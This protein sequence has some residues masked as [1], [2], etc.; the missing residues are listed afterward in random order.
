MQ[1]ESKITR[2]SIITKLV[3]TLKPLNY[4]HAMWEGGAAAF[5]RIDQYS[6][7]DLYILAKKRKTNLIIKHVENAL[8]SLSGINKQLSV[9]HSQWSDLTQIFYQLQRTSKYLLI[10]LV[11]L[12]QES[13]EKFLDPRVHGKVIFYFNKSKNLKSNRL[14][15]RELSNFL[16]KYKNKLKLKFDLFNIFVQKEINRNHQVEAVNL[17]YKITMKTLIDLLRIKYSPY[18]YNFNLQYLSL[19][20][21]N[22]ALQKL[23]TLNYIKNMDDLKEKYHKSTIWVNDLLR[24]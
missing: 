23:D 22:R 15:K 20:I 18:H 13:P 4:V 21:P 1:I 5:D 8:T 7:I 6:D 10:D 12:N 9:N 16:I 3:K 2:N 24:K 14:S 17:Y 19:E 11:I